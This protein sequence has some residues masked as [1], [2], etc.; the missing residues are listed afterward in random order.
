[1]NK[2]LIIG[3]Q[4]PEPNSSAAGT[5]MLQLIGCLQSGGYAVEFACAASASEFAVDLES[6]QVFLC[7]CFVIIVLISI[8]HS[9]FRIL[10]IF[11][12]S[13]I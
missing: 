6:M 13:I 4:W 3:H 11:Q 10:W 12:H 2:A 7:I 1:M 5:R 9:D 8:R